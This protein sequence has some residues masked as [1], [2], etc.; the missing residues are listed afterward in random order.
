MSI[1][2]RVVCVAVAAL[3]LSPVT[4]VQAQKTSAKQVVITNVSYDPDHGVLTIV[5]QQF[6]DS[7]NVWLAGEP[8]TVVNSTSDTIQAA[9]TSIPRAG[10]Y[11]LSV[12]RGPS[13]PDN[14]G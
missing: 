5:G 4:T 12:S 9:L 2:T 6:G 7:V 1:R 14:A 3:A 10:T 13:T 8:L 11:L